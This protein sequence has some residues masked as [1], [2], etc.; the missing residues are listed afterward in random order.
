MDSSLL[1]QHDFPGL[2][3]EGF[4]V[5]L[6]DYAVKEGLTVFLSHSPT[7]RALIESYDQQYDMAT[8]D[9]L[10]RILMRAN[11]RKLFRQTHLT[12]ATQSDPSEAIGAGD[13][14]GARVNAYGG[15]TVE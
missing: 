9:G 5:S 11:P 14:S 13:L 6:E 8:I 10:G 12:A 15:F 4:E 2:E 3:A 1:V 7:Q